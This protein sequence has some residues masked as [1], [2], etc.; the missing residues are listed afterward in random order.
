[1]TDDDKTLLTEVSDGVLTL[2]INRADRGNALDGPTTAR[3]I[4]TIDELA[5]DPGDVRAVLVR[6]AGKHFCTGADI[7]GAAERPKDGQK[8]ASGHLVRMLAAG[9]HRLIEALWDLRLPVVAEL[10]GRSSGM[11]LHLALACD[12]AIAARSATLSEPF[13]ERGFNVDSGGS[14]LLPRLVGLTRAKHLLYSAEPIDAETAAAWGLVFEVVDDD[15]VADRARE[16]AAKLA[17]GPTIALGE[18][19]RLLHRNLDSSLPLALEREASSIELTTRSGDFKEGMR[20]FV[21]R[22]PPEFTGR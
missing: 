7:G 20:A 17:A 16:A 9:P 14:W 21:E 8:P 10:T 2:T 18:I 4:A 22:R 11:G 12:Y 5:A 1:M 6:G 3:F 13:A 15:A 19:K